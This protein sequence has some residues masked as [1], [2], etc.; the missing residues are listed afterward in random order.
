MPEIQT[1]ANQ[2]LTARSLFPVNLPDPPPQDGLILP[3]DYWKE[4]KRQIRLISGRENSWLTAAFSFSSFGVS[5]L[6][7]FYELSGIPTWM[8]A[9]FGIAVGGAVVAFVGFFTNRKSRESGIDS[10]IIYMVNIE[11]RQRGAKIE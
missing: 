9:L 7:A 2:N 5:L 6:L 3:D 1:E 8:W 11:I 10:V 4:I